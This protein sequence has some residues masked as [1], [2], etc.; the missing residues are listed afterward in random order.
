MSRRTVWSAVCC[1]TGRPHSARLFLLWPSF[2]EAQS[3]TSV[4]ERAFSPHWSLL[5]HV[6]SGLFCDCCKEEKEGDRAEWGPSFVSPDVNNSGGKPIYLDEAKMNCL[7]SFTFCTNSLNGCCC[8]IYLAKAS[9]RGW[10]NA[11]S[12]QWTK[13]HTIF[14][15]PQ[16][17]QPGLFGANLVVESFTLLYRHISISSWVEIRNISPNEKNKHIYRIFLKTN[18]ESIVCFFRISILAVM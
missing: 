10:H 3:Q 9:V 14:C 18:L 5:V 4:S 1:W 6:T 13:F 17:Y 12:G 15:L 7:K 16:M 8:P 11:I 2:S